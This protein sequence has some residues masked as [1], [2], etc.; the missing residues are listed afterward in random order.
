MGVFSCLPAG[1]DAS[2]G[3]EGMTCAALLAAGARCDDHQDCGLEGE[4]LCWQGSCAYGCEDAG[5]RRRPCVEGFVCVAV[6]Q[7][8]HPWGGLCLRSP[9]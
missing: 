8:V 1:L 7:E 6:A 9:E 3:D 4:G 5:A 2:E